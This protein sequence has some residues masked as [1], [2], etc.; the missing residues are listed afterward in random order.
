M[1]D[2]LAGRSAT[3]LAV[4]ALLVTAAANG[5]H[6]AWWCLPLLLLATI[7]HAR[8]RRCA[9]TRYRVAVRASGWQSSLPAGCC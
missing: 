7:W 9:A 4:G 1:N 5:H 2:R 6:L 3:M 8:A